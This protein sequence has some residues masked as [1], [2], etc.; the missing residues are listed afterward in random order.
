MQQY[1][2]DVKF[3][4]QQNPANS[5]TQ[6]ITTKTLYKITCHTS[7]Q[8]H[9]IHQNHKVRMYYR[10]SQ[11]GLRGSVCEK[12]AEKPGAGIGIQER[13]GWWQVSFE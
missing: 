4:L 12:T 1:P 10:Q 3:A 2:F 8:T 13:N 11:P 5:H 6:Q 9:L 7:H